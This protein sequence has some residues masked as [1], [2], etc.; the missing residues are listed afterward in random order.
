MLSSL[1][2]AKDLGSTMSD[3]TPNTEP[4]AGEYAIHP[5]LGIPK[6]IAWSLGAGILG[7]VFGGALVGLGAAVAAPA[8]RDRIRKTHWPSRSKPELRSCR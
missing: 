3:K 4:A 1:K 8:I 7:I 6:Q 2:S 5:S